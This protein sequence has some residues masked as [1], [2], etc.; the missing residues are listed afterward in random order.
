MV[1][2]INKKNK[3][4]TFSHTMI[5]LANLRR[6]Q[7]IRDLQLTRDPAILTGQVEYL[8]LKKPF[9]V[10]CN[11]GCQHSQTIIVNSSRSQR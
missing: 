6:L 10:D 5:H 3:S 8:Q 9:L 4:P 11:Y 1:T 7:N 2:N